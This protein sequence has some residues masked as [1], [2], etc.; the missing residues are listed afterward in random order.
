MNFDDLRKLATGSI[1]FDLK[2]IITPRIVTV[3]YFLGLAAIVLWAVNHFFY[4]FR[5]GFGNGLWGLLEIVV[6]GMLSFIVLRVFCEAVIVYFRA[7]QS[8]ASQVTR[9]RAGASL[10]DDVRDAIEEL[11]EEEDDEDTAA[12]ARA[13]T[14]A[15]GATLTPTGAKTAPVPAEPKSPEP[16]APKT[17]EGSDAIA[18]SPAEQDK[19]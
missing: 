13:A 8:E 17:G 12:P 19:P 3:L 15:P 6:F 7:H 10:L 9:P 4:S 2:R 1:L 5:F 11:A 18:P 16:A 14:A